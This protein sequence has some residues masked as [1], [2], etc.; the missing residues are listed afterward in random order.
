MLALW[1]TSLFYLRFFVL[2]QQPCDILGINHSDPP[3]CQLLNQ[4]NRDVG[5]Y[6]K[7]IL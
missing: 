7:F 2:P 3:A 4:Q 1:Y 6:S 5:A